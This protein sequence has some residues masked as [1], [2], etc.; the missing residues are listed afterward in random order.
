LGFELRKHIPDPDLQELARH[1]LFRMCNVVIAIRKDPHPNEPAG[2]RSS[3]IACSEGSSSGVRLVED[4]EGKRMYSPSKRIRTG[5]TQVAG[6]FVQ[7]GT[8]Q[9]LGMR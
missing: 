7:E 9:K 3:E 2:S 4:G 6:I 8:R 5:R 1:V